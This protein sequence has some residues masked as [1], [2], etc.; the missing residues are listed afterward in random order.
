MKFKPIPQILK[1]TVKWHSIANDKI[2]I[3]FEINSKFSNYKM[4]SILSLNIEDEIFDFCFAVSKDP[5]FLAPYIKDKF[6][7]TAPAKYLER[8]KSDRTIKDDYDL[9]NPDD[10]EEASLDLKV[11]VAYITL[12]DLI[13][14]EEA[15]LEKA[16]KLISSY[17]DIFNTDEITENNWNTFVRMFDLNKQPQLLENYLI[18]EK[19]EIVLNNG[20]ELYNSYI[21]SKNTKI[22]NVKY[23][24]NGF[25]INN[26]SCDN[27][28]EVIS[29]IINNIFSDKPNAVIKKCKLCGGLFLPKKS[30]TK[31][32]NRKNQQYNNKTCKEVSEA[33]NKKKYNENDQLLYLRRKVYNKLDRTNIQTPCDKNQK[34]LDKF[35]KEDKNITKKY[36]LNLITATEYEQWLLSFYKNKPK[37]E[38]TS[39]D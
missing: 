8:C 4:D 30:D 14:K 11:F 2:D 20:Q 15:D 9:D 39:N 36:K 34:E 23:I 27:S 6:E 16:T 33:I 19:Y 18:N 24:K 1:Y 17:S 22:G 13:I 3:V 12:E 35:W 38:V 7:K 10:F 37:S 28:K 31:Y 29:T 5:S 26:Y 32:C 21:N 25:T